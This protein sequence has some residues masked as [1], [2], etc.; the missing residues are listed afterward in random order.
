MKLVLFGDVHLEATFTWLGRDGARRRR[1]ALQQVVR[2][3]VTLADDWGAEALLCSGDL[4][5]HERSTPDTG[6]FLRHVFTDIAHIPIYVAPGNHDWFGPESLYAT[7]D[8]P[9]NVHIFSSNRLSE[10]RVELAD[11]LSLW[12]AAHK[13]PARTPGFFEAFRVSGDGLHLALV[14]ASELG[15]FQESGSDQNLHA[16]FNTEELRSSGLD[17]AFLGHIHKPKDAD[18]YTYPGNPD[19]LTFGETGERGPVLVTIDQDGNI[20]RERQPVSVTESR[21]VTVDI[22]ECASGHE[23]CEKVL[24]AVAPMSGYVRLSMKGALDPTVRFKVADLGPKPEGLEG[25][26][27]R[28]DQVKVAYDFETV[29]QE[30]TVRGQF[31]R[32]VMA[33]SSLS[34]HDR[35]RV[36][37]TGLRALDGSEDLEVT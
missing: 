23:I 31:V 27:V 19:P 37:G 29:A 16:P 5:E 6:A 15:W 7:I 2:R 4:F 13:G 36:L 30:Q 12:G 35:K 11:G 28:T 20:Q 25:W 14:H 26:V 33:D 17:H 24:A 8:W 22:S 34:E 18:L 3:I 9:S 21:D 10:G 1:Q 32:D